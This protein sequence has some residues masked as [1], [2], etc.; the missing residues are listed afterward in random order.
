MAAPRFP[1]VPSYSTNMTA[2]DQA[3][4][5][6]ENRGTRNATVATTVIAL[7]LFGTVERVVRKRVGYRAGAVTHIKQGGDS[8]W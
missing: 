5:R 3:W 7:S 8:I 2:V 6:R 4:K 1:I